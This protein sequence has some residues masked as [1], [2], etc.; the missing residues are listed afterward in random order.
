LA[1]E[2]LIFDDLCFFNPH[3][4]VAWM[5]A[6]LL[7]KKMKKH[8]SESVGLLVGIFPQTFRMPALQQLLL[9]LFQ[10]ISGAGHCP[11]LRRGHRA[12]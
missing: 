2:I 4:F 7:G 5:P 10:L 11:G 12:K 3:V 8:I 1:G 9:R 6:F